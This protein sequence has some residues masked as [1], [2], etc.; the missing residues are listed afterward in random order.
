MRGKSFYV[1]NNDKE[2]SVY[3]KWQP[4]KVPR[5]SSLSPD[6]VYICFKP[7]TLSVKINIGKNVAQLINFKDR[8]RV[9]FAYDRL[10]LFKVK[11][12]KSAAYH[13]ALIGT[14]ESSN[15]ISFQS[16]LPNILTLDRNMT[17]STEVNYDF[18]QGNNEAIILDL[19]PFQIKGD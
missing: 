15:V 11:I 10:N 19:S 1:I 2:L 12:E 9:V 6:S 13:G 16:K 18:C 14:T 8:E 5:R 3:P 7:D 17:V 4:F